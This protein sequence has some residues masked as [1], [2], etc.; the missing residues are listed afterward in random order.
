MTRFTL[1]ILGT[2]LPAL[3]LAAHG[4]RAEPD[5]TDLRPISEYVRTLA[6]EAAADRIAGAAVNARTAGPIAPEDLTPVVQ[7]YCVVCHNDASMTGN[8]SLASFEVE[9][10]TDAPETSERVIRKLRAG[11]MPPAGMKR[12]GGDTLQAL[13]VVLEEQMDELF[14][15]DPNPGRRTFQRLNRD[16]YAHS[17]R[18]LLGLEVDVSAFLPAETMS[19]N[20]D[21]IA[22]VQMLS[23]TLMEGYLRA[24]SQIAR[25]AVG[26]PDA[27]TSE[28]WYKVPR[29]AS[30]LERVEGAPFGTRGGT[31]V[32]HTREHNI[33]VSVSATKDEMITVPDSTTANSRNS[34]PTSPPKNRIGR[35]TATSATVVAMTAR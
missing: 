29:T 25:D 20:F 1:F 17:I 35:K 13:A 7:Q 9:N 8:L 30:Q 14:E 16:E 10:A 23:P 11:M 2:G 26:D 15:D 31:S 21:N 22:D 12:P 27:T 32:M 3:G 34:R 24:A 5:L 28:T 19:Q 33:G 18:D 4:L 6:V